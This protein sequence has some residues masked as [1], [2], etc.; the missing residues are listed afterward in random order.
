MTNTIALFSIKGGV[1]KTAAAVNLAAL[2]A[3][4]G[5][6][7]LIWDLDPQAAT[8]WY[9]KSAAVEGPSIRRIF[10]G[11]GLGKAIRRTP[12]R[13]LWLL[14]SDLSYRDAEQVL[15]DLKHGV[16]QIAHMLESLY[17]EYDEIWIDCPPGLSLLADN[18]IRAAQVL[19]VPLVPTHLSERTWY[20]LLEHMNREKIHPEHFHA[21][22]SLVDRRRQLHRNF[23]NE[24]ARR[25]PQLLPVEIPYASVVE[26][27]GVDRMPT[28]F[29]H[30][31]TPAAQAYF[32]LWQ[33]IDE[34]LD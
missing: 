25:I 24:H 18:V 1:G 7:T 5:R 31:R 22:L 23:R 4:H 34:L 29:S 8:T 28:V 30:S 11:K 21:F 15:G 14:P 2:S 27:M 17:D 13:N 10:K 26:Q 19:L 16:F 12:H 3:L 32:A 33:Q 20:Q 9:L 6:R